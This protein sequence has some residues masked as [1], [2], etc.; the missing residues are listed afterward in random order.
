MLGGILRL[1]ATIGIRMTIGDM[2]KLRLGRAKFARWSRIARLRVV[3]GNAAV[4]GDT[5]AGTG[6][7]WD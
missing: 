2:L 6:S 5:T 7:R 4:G 1:L 3:A